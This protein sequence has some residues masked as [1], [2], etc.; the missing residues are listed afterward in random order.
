M[1]HRARSMATL[2]LAVALG[3][4]GQ[5]DAIDESGAVFDG[6]APQA[7]VTLSGTEPFWSLRIEPDEGK[8]ATARFSTPEDIEGRVFTVSRF[9]GN[10]GLGFSGELDGEP[11]IAALTPGECSDAMSD[12]RYPYVATVSL[13]EARLRGCGYTS[14]EGFAGPEAP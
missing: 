5:G 9:A 14:D 7:I 2:A 10:N 12:R 6:V 8:T 1:G 4:C 11:V 13:G 3:A